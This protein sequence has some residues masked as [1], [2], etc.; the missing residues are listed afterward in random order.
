MTQEFLVKEFWQ[1]CNRVTFPEAQAQ[2]HQV[3]RGPEKKRRLGGKDK[4]PITHFGL[5]QFHSGL[6]LWMAADKAD[7]DFHKVLEV[8]VMLRF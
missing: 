1:F 2:G 8:L 5:G 7:S 6:V 3:T 4:L